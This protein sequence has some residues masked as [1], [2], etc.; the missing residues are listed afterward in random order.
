MKPAVPTGLPMTSLPT[1]TP[2]R[3]APAP[4]HQRASRRSGAGGTLLGLFV[5]LVL[6]LGLAAGVAYYLMKAGN[7]YQAS[8]AAKEP[9]RDP[10]RE[11]SRAGRVEPGV[12]EKPR[13][14]FYKILPGVEEPKIQAKAGERTPPDRATMERALAPERGAPKADERA[15]AKVDERAAAPS[16]AA[17]SKAMPDKAA[18]DKVPPERAAPDKGTQIRDRFWLQ[19]GSFAAESDAEGLKAQ[20]ALAG[21]EA[22]IQQANLPDKGARFRVRLGP[23]DNTEELNRVKTELGK[24]GFDAAV[25]KQ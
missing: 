24:R 1:R 5:G 9:V 3:A 13:F 17:P 14:D 8:T 21:W 25:I 23:Y 11:P 19:A 18:P 7:P 22:A 10:V 20:L 12:A 4:R 2:L 6:G 16:K 15:I